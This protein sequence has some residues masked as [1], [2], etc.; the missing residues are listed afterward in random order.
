MAENSPKASAQSEEGSGDSA[1]R[2]R[3]G[4]QPQ[5]NLAADVDAPIPAEGH[6]IRSQDDARFHDE[7]ALDARVE[8]RP[9]GAYVN[10][11]CEGLGVYFI[12]SQPPFAADYPSAQDAPLCALPVQTHSRIHDTFRWLHSDRKLEHVDIEYPGCLPQP[13]DEALS[14]I[15]ISLL[16]WYAES[17]R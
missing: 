3:A 16:T 11:N 9:E 4:P 15:L 17:P 13:P 2:D 12:T 14:W 7:Q 8:R 10:Y 1:T 6:P 5:A